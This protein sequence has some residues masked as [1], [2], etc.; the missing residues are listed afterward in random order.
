VAGALPDRDVTVRRV[1]GLLAGERR[2]AHGPDEPVR[3]DDDQTRLVAA[4]SRWRRVSVARWRA[5]T[6]ARVLPNRPLSPEEQAEIRERLIQLGYV[7][8]P[9]PLESQDGDEE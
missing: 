9:K 4:W 2:A 6:A 3:G 7:A 8:R 5:E 1:A